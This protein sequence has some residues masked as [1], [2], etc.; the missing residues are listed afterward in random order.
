MILD[1]GGNTDMPESRMPE[2]AGEFIRVEEI[3]VEC[4]IPIGR[5]QGLSIRECMGSHTM[6]EVEAGM[7]AGSFR[8]SDCQLNSQPL[9]VKA[10][11]NGKEIL[12]FSGVIHE[13][14]MDR[15][16]VYD[17]IHILAYSVTWFMDLEMKSRSFQGETSVLGLI[18]KI[19]GEHAFS[20]LAS[21]PDRM[22]K[23]AFIQYRE[24]DWEFMLRLS[25]HLQASLFAANEYGGKGIHI[26]IQEKGEPVELYEWSEKWCMDAEHVKKMGFD[27]QKAVYH[28]VVSSQVVHLGQSVSFH[29]KIC[30]PYRVDLFLRRGVLY[31]IYRLAG[32]Q[33]DTVSVRFHPLLKGISLE[34]TVLERD[35]ETIKVHLDMDEEQ[36]RNLARPYPWMPEHGNMA[37]CMPEV[38]SRIRLLVAGEKNCPAAE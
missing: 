26:G 19:A 13:V 10:V 24:T 28:E 11:K 7:E 34:G 3:A 30:W 17:T 37:Y 18:E 38:G 35:G 32:R 2:N 15:E 25:T 36:D 31:G 16:A 6:A 14:R 29:N 1:M 22:T 20:V 5:I 23:G 27:I 12:L 4:N 33:Y 8:V 9:V 21:V